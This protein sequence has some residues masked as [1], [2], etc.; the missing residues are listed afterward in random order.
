L[1][2]VAA[3]VLQVTAACVGPTARR[4]TA[5]PPDLPVDTA[6]YA[7]P[8]RMAC[9]GDSNTEGYGLKHPGAE[10]YPAQLQQMLNKQDWLVR[11]FGV[12]ATTL[13]NHGDRPYQRTPAFQQAL[14]FNP[15]VVVIMLGTNDTKP[16]N[17]VHV[18]QFADDYRNLVAQFQALP[19]H[20]RVFICH[21]I[22]VAA[23]GK[24]GINEPNVQAE[25]PKIDQVARETGA[26]VIDL[27]AVLRG[28]EALLP[29]HV[30][31]TAEGA[32]LLAAAV[33]QA[34]TGSRSTP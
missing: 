15:D 19:S 24:W 20:P 31:P 7:K 5:P 12:S 3:A 1:I 11:N 18:D 27:H 6:R 2:W 8:I 34:L 25:L 28:H 14:A 13:L 10:S 30:H 33:D 22:L 21:P 29:D 16:V 26:G 9:V 23:E 32:R 17:W 4:A